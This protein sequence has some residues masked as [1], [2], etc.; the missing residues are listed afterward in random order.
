MGGWGR[1]GKGR[2]SFKMKTV[3]WTVEENWYSAWNMTSYISHSEPPLQTMVTIQKGNK[4]SKYIFRFCSYWKTATKY[5]KSLQRHTHVQLPD[6]HS[7]LKTTSTH[8]THTHIYN[9]QSI[10][11]AVS[12]IVWGTAPSTYED[13]VPCQ[14]Q[15]TA[16]KRIRVLHKP[17]HTQKNI[18]AV[19]L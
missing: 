13:D 2:K 9:I 10:D 18:V 15:T 8:Y 7:C 1:G 19:P 16:A 6:I 14:F 3:H 4:T 17:L 12:I 11:D 5:S